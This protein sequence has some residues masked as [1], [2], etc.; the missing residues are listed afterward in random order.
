MSGSRPAL[1][2]LGGGR[3][4]RV[5]LPARAPPPP[6]P[7]TEAE[8]AQLIAKRDALQEKIRTLVI[9]A[10]EK[11]LERAPKAGIM[12]G[13]P[14]AL[15]QA[16]AEQVVGG[17]FSRM[18]LTL[19]NLKAHKAGD[20]KVKMLFRS[21]SGST[22]RREHH[23]DPGR[24]EAR[25]AAVPLRERPSRPHPPGRA[26]RRPR[27]R[28]DPLPLGQQGPGRQH[29]VRRHGGDQ[30]GHGR[31]RPRGVRAERRLRRHDAGRGGDPP[32]RIRGAR[33]PHRRESQRPGLGGGGRGG[34]GPARRLRG[35]PRQDRHQGQAGRHRRP[36][37]Q[38]EDT[39]E[40]PA[41]DPPAR[42]APAVA[43]GPGPA[44]RRGGQADGRAREPRPALVRGRRGAGKDAKR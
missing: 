16:I 5:A 14:T 41:P 36:R 24:A 3:S 37:L 44:V 1:V 6:P 32:A 13:V 26:R 11:S 23:R 39:E 7:T 20:V 43:R 18:T 2:L 15:T 28:R 40:A 4:G 22:T 29:G 10:G 33:R 30:G 12:I 38:R 17:F 25:Q 27:P 34:E 19:R 9:A 21:R 31:R 8:I 42:G 35:R